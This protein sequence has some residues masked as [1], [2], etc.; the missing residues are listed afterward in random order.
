MVK[1]SLLFFIF[2]KIQ[3]ICEHTNSSGSLF[4]GKK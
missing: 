3:Y 4:Y 1:S 2:V